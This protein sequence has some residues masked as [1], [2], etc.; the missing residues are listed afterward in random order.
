MG[1]PRLS[2]PSRT[3]L[4]EALQNPHL[5]LGP[6]ALA[7]VEVDTDV[8]GLPRGVAGANAVVF[9]VVDEG[10]PVA[11][12]CFTRAQPDRDRRYQA[13]G[14][15]LADA[16]LPFV[17][18]TELIED[19][20]L[21]RGQRWPALRMTWASG[22]DLVSWVRDHIQDP[23]AVRRLAEAFASV[24]A[25]LEAH[26]IAHGDL[27]HGNILVG[28]QGGITLVDYDGAYVP[29]IA[30]LGPIEA[31]HASYQH[32]AR[33]GEWGDHLDR[34]SAWLIYTSLL[35]IA[36]EPDLWFQIPRAGEDRLLLG[37]EDI[38]DPDRSPALAVLRR[39][40]EPIVR[41]CASFLES[42]CR[43]PPADHR[44]LDP[45]ALP[46][47]AFGPGAGTEEGD[48]LPPPPDT[49]I[50]DEGGPTHAA[51]PV[52]FSAGLGG[53]RAT[54]ASSVVAGAVGAAVWG[55]PALLVAVLVVAA[56]VASTYLR[57]PERLQAQAARLALGDAE[58][59][60]RKDQDA[61]AA[62]LAARVR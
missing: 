47:L 29:A 1:E 53:V 56:I 27:Q 28:P 8:L 40:R 58:R 39:S 26:G 32:P 15:A 48:D 7:R 45:A 33:S 62:A 30:D 37:E 18:A 34:F 36:I 59:E 11:L 9:K 61:L 51:A 19:A 21:V 4:A 57:R 38:L 25:R 10:R 20:V 13:I 31:G 49:S 22:Q 42:L 50:T 46:S 16:D 54:V 5:T 41:P 44:P 52:G 43:T 14:A 35:V 24:V 6:E 2:W 23:A 55:A 3:E 12:K 60:E 17:V